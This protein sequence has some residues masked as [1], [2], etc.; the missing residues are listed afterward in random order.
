[1]TRYEK[2]E[3]ILNTLKEKNYDYKKYESTQKI[4]Q[5]LNGKEF[6]INE[7]ISSLIYSLLSSQRPWKQIEK[8]IDNINKIFNGFDPQYLKQVDP[9]VLENKIKSIKCGNRQ[10]HTQMNSIRENILT[11][12]KIIRDY[13]SVDNFVT[14][15]K[16]L[17]IAKIISSGKY[18]MKGVGLSLALEYLKGVGIDTVKPDVHICR[19]LGR[20]KISKNKIATQQEA[21]ELIHDIAKHFNMFDMEV[22]TIL[23]QYCADGYLEICT[24][25]PK[26]NVC[27]L[28]GICR[29]RI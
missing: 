3:L 24:S 18:K 1:M 7:H 5:R 11:F 13:G 10:I 4:E 29:K 27:K 2:F 12:E 20:M 17:N 21:L 15:D 25:N 22:D 9:L 14:S 19:I 28:N 16:P 26:C 6:K 23:W 8:N